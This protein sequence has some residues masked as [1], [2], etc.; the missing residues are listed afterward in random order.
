MQCIQ[1]CIQ[2]PYLL[3][4]PSSYKHDICDGRDGMNATVIY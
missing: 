4:N 1:K 2:R 3:D